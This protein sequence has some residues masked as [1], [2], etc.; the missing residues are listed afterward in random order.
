M[1]MCGG[2]TGTPWTVLY[3]VVVL[4]RLRAMLLS[5]C[6]VLWVGQM[7]IGKVWV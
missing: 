3:D 4:S 5:G 1:L 2:S 6:P 7:P